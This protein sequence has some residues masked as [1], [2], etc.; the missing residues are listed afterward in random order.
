[1]L[2]TLVAQV[3]ALTARVAEL[4]AKLGLPP[5]TPDNSSVPPSKGQKAS[6]PSK[7]RPKANPHAGA[8]RPLG[9]AKWL[10]RQPDLAVFDKWWQ[11]SRPSGKWAERYFADSI[12][13]IITK[14]D[15]ANTEFRTAERAVGLVERYRLASL[16]A[17]RADRIRKQRGRAA[18]GL[19][20]G[21]ALISIAFSTGYT[22]YENA[23]VAR[24][25]A[26]RANAA[27]LRERAQ[28]IA[29]RAEYALDREGPAKALLFAEQA[30]KQGLPD[31][32]RTERVLISALKLLRER[33]VISGLT[34]PVFGV[35]YSPDGD[36]IASLDNGS[37]LFWDA[38]DGKLVDKV[39]LVAPGS[40]GLTWSAKADW[41][42]VNLRNKTLLLRPCSHER[43][44]S[45]F[46]SCQVGESDQSL[47][48]GDPGPAAGLPKFSDDGTWVV[49]GS[50]G[51]LPV[52]WNIATRSATP[53]GTKKV[54]TPNDVG[55]SPDSK[56][57]ALGFETNTA[58]CL[59]SH[60]I[61]KT[62]I[63]WRRR[64]KTARLSYG[65]SILVSI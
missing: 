10:K 34:N 12:F 1:M 64:C 57:I 54:A 7:P 60:S 11:G 50:W 16:D 32:P 55:L 39:S 65:T 5:K 13:P 28:N 9:R 36:V 18:I 43:I 38:K 58:T 25:S 15:E 41:I 47:I 3:A 35:A 46:P 48:L 14:A 19:V 37:L 33:R 23:R 26:E 61:R 53:L 2:H 27:L 44:R 52:L 22:L 30:E 4:E 59:L 31:L 51:E 62:R 8:H 40:F 45:L 63:C 24:A 56:T 20:L 17:E 42:G 21:L 29:L 6:E 49:T